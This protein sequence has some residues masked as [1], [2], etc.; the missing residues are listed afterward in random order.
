MPMTFSGLE[1]VGLP[2]WPAWYREMNPGYFVS[3]SMGSFSPKGVGRNRRARGLTNGAGN[4]GCCG[5]NGNRAGAGAGV[6][7]AERL[8]GGTR[9]TV[10]DKATGRVMKSEELGE[11][12][13]ARLKCMERDA[14]VKKEKEQEKGPVSSSVLIDRATARDTRKWEDESETAGEEEVEE[15]EIEEVEKKEGKLVEV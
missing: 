4:A 3:E 6:A 11:Q 1:E 5:S 9:V 10:K 7:K 12:I 15:S 2:D 14:R 13:I 8:R